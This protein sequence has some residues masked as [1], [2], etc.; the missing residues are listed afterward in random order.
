MCI[1]EGAQSVTNTLCYRDPDA[2]HASATKPYWFTI[3][4]LAVSLMPATA[5]HPTSGLVHLAQPWPA[6]A[7]LNSRDRSCGVIKTP[8]SPPVPPRSRKAAEYSV[9]EAVAHPGAF[10]RA[11]E[12]FATAD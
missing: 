6:R 3:Q 11:P 7:G 5:G 1:S 8:R 4:V 9:S 2:V 12:Q 10:F